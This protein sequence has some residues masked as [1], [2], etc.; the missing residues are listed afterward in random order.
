MSLKTVGLLQYM[1]LAM[2]P[3][4]IPVAEGSET[5]IFKNILIDI[6]DEQSIDNDLSYL[7][8]LILS[9]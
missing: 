7:T 9:I 1:P 4:T 2:R 8:V 3:L 5:G 6:G